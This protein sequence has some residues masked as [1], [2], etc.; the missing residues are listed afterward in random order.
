MRRHLIF[1][2]IFLTFFLKSSATDQ[3]FLDS[4]HRVL[5]T[6]QNIKEKLN[7]LYTLSFEYGLIDPRKGIQYGQ[8]CLA[9][10]T[11]TNDPF[12]QYNAY[13]GMSNAYETLADFDSVRYC[14]NRSLEIGRKMR[15][16]KLIAMA[17]VNRA[18]S[19]KEQGDYQRAL[20]DYLEG[21]R[22]LEKEKE[23]NPRI[24]F[25]IGDMYLRIGNYAQAEYHA[26]HGIA[27]V[28]KLA[29]DTNIIL[30]HQ[31]ILSKC[32]LH[33]GKTDSAIALLRAS[34]SG[35]KQN[36]DQYSVSLCLGA[37]GEAYL[38]QALYGKALA[39]FSEELA[40]QHQLKNEN[41]K[42]LAYLNMAFCAAHVNSRNLAVASHLLRNAETGIGSI[43][44][45]KDIMRDTYYKLAQTFELI[46][47]PA[48]ALT[49]FKLYSA[50]SD[51]LLNKEKFKQI[52]ELQTRYETEKKEQRIREQQT[53]IM[54]QASVLEKKRLQLAAMIAALAFVIV[55]GLLFYFRH[56]AR[57]KIRFIM[58]VQ[59]QERLREQALAEK[60]KQERERI[61]KDIHDELG[62]G[63][64][65]ISL[66]AEYTM[67]RMNG[68]KALS[69]NIQVISKT[70]KSLVDNMRD[71]IWTLHADSCTLDDLA[72][73]MHE[74]GS[75]YLEDLSIRAHFDFPEEVPPI[76]I[77]KVAQRNIFMTF[78]E[79]MN[80]SVKHGGAKIFQVQLKI[81]NN[82]LG[83]A[84]SDNG[85]GFDREQ[86]KKTGNGLRNMEQRV[87]EIGG[88]FN[89]SSGQAGTS[90]A[91]ELQLD[92][93]TE[94]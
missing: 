14:H 20:D 80:N 27:Q 62:S 39:V 18:I 42:C 43:K 8:Q 81:R 70:S 86:I 33:A 34:L 73:R 36:T 63:L 48:R 85:K 94:A 11:Q 90:V 2:S 89:I 3:S 91:I 65:K 22:F 40:L 52:Q 75:E 64:S 44:K 92:E 37:L 49:Y 17:L 71:L 26:R 78:K 32:L 29:H 38:K 1:L 19:Y 68:D 45:N 7:C 35:L 82:Q 88:T 79:A 24:H 66:I 55:F 50:L 59:R 4:I 61:S 41:G 57:Q 16:N 47:E 69:E 72:A 77:T 12:F 23:Y 15:H 60:E 58:E 74:Y 46:R 67:Q 93:I 83:L 21:Y 53:E 6:T 10:A 76:R 84:F 30:N 87:R 31:I 54:Q 25:Y 5:N 56:R 51:S 13:N 28:K 9:L